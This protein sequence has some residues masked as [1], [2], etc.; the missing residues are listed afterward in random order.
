MSR[1]QIPFVAALLI[2]AVTL[3]ACGTGSAPAGS[4]DMPARPEG[5]PQGTP[6]ADMP[7][8]SP[9]MNEKADG[10]EAPVVEATPTAAATSAV[11]VA[12]TAEATA[13]PQ[14]AEPEEAASQKPEQEI[15]AVVEI[16]NKT[17]NKTHEDIDAAE[18]NLSAAL[19]T[20]GGTLTVGYANVTKSGDSTSLENSSLFGQNAAILGTDKSTLKV[21]Y[22]TVKTSGAG[23]AGVYVRGGETYGTVLDT[24]IET[25]GD[26]APALMAA[27]EASMTVSNATLI[28][29]G[30]NSSAI[31]TD[32][33]NAAITIDGSSASTSGAN[34][35]GIS[36][37]AS[38]DVS[39]SN[40]SVA[41]SASPAIAIEGTSTVNAVDSDLSTSAEDQPAV[42]FFQKADNEDSGAAFTMSGGSLSNSGSNGAL[43]ANSGAAGTVELSKVALS[44]KSGILIRAQAGE[45]GEGGELT[46]RAEGS[47]LAGKVVVDNASKVSLELM[48]GATFDGM[49]NSE[50]T[51]YNANLTLD[52]SSSW[53]VTGKSYLTKLCDADGISGNSVTNITGNGYTVY[54]NSN[55]NIYLKGKI[56]TLKGG[57]YLKPLN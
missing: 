30:E 2:L 10:A 25:S 37:T 3:S 49:I 39:I 5:A 8:G 55:A 33:G 24:T 47:N 23:A 45:D 32:H 26:N 40:S 4:A 14:A 9:P 43:I 12:A 51:A 21:L 57:G 17:Y 15:A 34:S 16:G 46:V 53:N 42:S 28:T 41:A 50:Y 35:A 38:G 44:A 22:S 31:A 19:V 52:A 18:A 6:P 36:A 13:A 1:L 11:E 54:Y 48:D 56:Y 20:N 29:S 27:L 7:E